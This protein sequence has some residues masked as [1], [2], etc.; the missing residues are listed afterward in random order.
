MHTDFISIPYS[1]LFEGPN[2]DTKPPKPTTTPSPPGPTP[3]TEPT[4]EPT[5]KPTIPTTPH[6]V[7]PSADACQMEMFD[8]ITEIQGKLHFFKDG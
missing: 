3:E 1:F 5:R 6:P 4:E 8:A 2:P 7:D